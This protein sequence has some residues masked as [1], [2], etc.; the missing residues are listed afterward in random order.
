MVKAVL[1]SVIDTDERPPPLNPNP[2]TP[3]SSRT[4]ARMI[5][6]VLAA[7][8]LHLPEQALDAPTLCGRECTEWL[9]V[10][11]MMRVSRGGLL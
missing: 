3:L 1:Q 11:T 8:V 2:T 5:W 9:R 7:L 6:V 4:C 10:H